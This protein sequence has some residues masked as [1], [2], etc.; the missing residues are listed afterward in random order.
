MLMLGCSNAV[1]AAERRATSEVVTRA[2]Q[3]GMVRVLGQ[4]RSEGQGSGT[5]AAEVSAI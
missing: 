3:P 5:W 1:L 2:N 4:M